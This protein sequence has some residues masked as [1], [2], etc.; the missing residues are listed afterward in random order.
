[1]AHE[2]Y[3][4][5]AGIL[6]G[7]KESGPL[8]ESEM[9]AIA[10]QGKLK[11]DSLVMSPT[12]TN[13]G[14]HLVTQIAGLVKAMDDGDRARQAEKEA[15]AQRKAAA[16]QEAAEVAQAQSQA[17]GQRLEQQ[18][19]G[20]HERHARSAQISH[21]SNPAVVEALCQ[22][23]QSILTSQEV[24]QY[25]AVQQKPLI[26]LSPDAMIA[27][28]RRLIFFRAKLLGRFEFQD[29]QWFD[30]GNAHVQQNLLG[31]VFTARHVSGQILSMDYLPKESAAAI[32]RLS[33]ER[34]EQA[35]IARHQMHVDTIRAGAS[36]VNVNTNAP[37]A[38]AAPSA[39]PPADDLIAR[40]EKLKMMA[41][42]GLITMADFEKRKQEI[43]AQL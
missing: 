5:T 13:G 27:T 36:Q 1:M 8:P 4:R 25:V 39:A 12:R 15:G 18:R 7:V 6:G 42:K 28:N 40:L 38:P 23:I 22:K 10:M 14:W 30:L 32:Y 16:R 9:L 35:R 21:H 17:N 3:H 11:Q 24:I 33:Q 29:Y 31:S 19:A 37:A 34:E 2:W 26:N 43:L 41:D 20:Q